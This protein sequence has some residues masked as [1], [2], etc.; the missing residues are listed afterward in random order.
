M[1]NELSFDLVKQTI[2]D[3]LACLETNFNKYFLPE[4][5]NNKFDWIR[6][7]FVAKIEDIKHLSLKAQEELA[8]LSSD[9]NLKNDFSVK[10][11]NTFW[12]AVKPEFPTLSALAMAVLL[13]FVTTYLCE[14]AFS[15]LTAL[16]AKHRSSIKN[17]ETFM[18]PA[19][20]NIQPRFDLLCENKQSHPSH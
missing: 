20:T 1:N 3:H 19:L 12:L 17:I 16:K 15:T 10:N 13:P 9:S 2:L 11:L 14:S 6:N 18:R 4:L 7:P 8:E 5:D